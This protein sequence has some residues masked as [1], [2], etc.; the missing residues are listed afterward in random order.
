M[1]MPESD[2]EPGPGFSISGLQD[3]PGDGGSGGPK[4]H[5]GGWILLFLVFLLV[6][7]VLGGLAYYAGKWK[8]EVEVREIVVD[9]AALVPSSDIVNVLKECR[10]SNMLELDTEI[11]KK[12]VLRFPYVSDA[13]FSKE[14]NGVVR[15]RLFEREPLALTV[16]DGK[17]AAIDR[18]GVLLPVDNRILVLFPKLPAVSGIS[19]LRSLPNGLQ[20]IDSI[21]AG[22]IV[23]FFTALAQTDYASLLINEL[24][25]ADNNMSYCLTRQSPTQFILGNDGNFKEKLKKFEIFWQK[26]VSK[27]GFDVYEAVDLRFRDRVFTRDTV[28]VKVPQQVSP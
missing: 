5:K 21:E 22:L 9:G 16:I 14:M 8:K 23:D 24:H 13:V 7:G 27:K 12:R 2:Y 10:G 25:L 20:R 15:V 4:R 3:L 11:L 1:V 28:S 26:V 19:R 17:T 18:E 6:L